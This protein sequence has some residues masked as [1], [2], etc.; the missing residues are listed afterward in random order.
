MQHGVAL[1]AGARISAVATVW[2][3]DPS[4]ELRWVTASLGA[5]MQGGGAEP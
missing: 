1:M 5:M 2:L 4:T 3:S